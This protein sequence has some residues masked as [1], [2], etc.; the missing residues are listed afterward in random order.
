MNQALR[1]IVF[2]AAALFLFS[3]AQWLIVPERAAADLGM[4]VLDGLGRSTQFGDMA[5]FF[6]ALGLM[7]LIAGITRQRTWFYP[8]AML[9]GFA[10][11]GRSLAWLF[12]DAVFATQFIVLEAVIAALLLFAAARLSTPES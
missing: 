5:A 8:P 9:L 3:G 4:P 7:T 12:H 11:I 1:V 2:L 6:I 10:A